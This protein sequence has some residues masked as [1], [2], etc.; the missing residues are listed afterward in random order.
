MQGLQKF[1]RSRKAWL[2]L[3]FSAIGLEAA[4]LFFQ[5]V[6][7]L[8]PCVMCVYVRV[9]VL[10]LIISAM[11]GVMVPR[12]WLTRIMALIG[13]GVSAVWGLK[14]SLE[15]N[16]LQVDPSPFSTCNF[17]P[18]FPSWMPL[19]KWLPEVFSPTGMC[20]DDPWTFLSV[21]MAQWTVVTFI[22]YLVILAIMLIPAIKPSK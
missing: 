4:A 6:M 14:L 11:I 13:W 21:S 22:I 16:K 10:G 12:F 2:L 5:Y 8:E 9:A 20:S 19:D 17:F 18:D 1:A 3:L 7:H 15:L